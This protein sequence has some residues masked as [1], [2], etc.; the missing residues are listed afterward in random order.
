[1][2]RREFLKKAGITAASATLAPLMFA[3]ILGW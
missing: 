1:M 2:Q 3:M